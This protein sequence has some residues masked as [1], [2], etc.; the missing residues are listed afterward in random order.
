MPDV[1]LDH[2]AAAADHD[3][4]DA[5]HL[6][7]LVRVVVHPHVVRVRVVDADRFPAVRVEDDQVGVAAHSDGPLLREQP[8]QLGGRGRRQLDELVHR[9][10]AARH[11]AVVD[12]AHPVLD[13]R[14]AV[15]D[16][17]EVVYPQNLLV[18]ETERA[19]VGRDALQIAEPEPPPQ[20]VL[21]PLLPQRRRHDVLGALEVLL[22]VA[23]Q[24][25]E[26][27]LGAGLGEHLSAAVP[28]QGH[29]FERVRAAQVDDVDRHARHLGDRDRAMHSLRLHAGG[30]GQ[31]VVLRRRLALGHCQLDDLVDDDPVLGVHA[32]QGAVLA[33][34][35]H[36]AE[37]RAV[38]DV[39]QARVGHEHLV[40]GHALV[41][42]P[43]HLPQPVVLHVGDDHVEA[44]VDARLAGRLLVPGLEPLKRRLA[45]G[46]DREVDDR[47]RTA[48]GGRPGAGLEV[49]G[50]RRA[51][52]GHVHVGVGVDA[53]RH[54]QP[55][56]RVD[57]PVRLDLQVAADQRDR[58][59]LYEDV[60]AVVVHRRHDATVTNQQGHRLLLSCRLSASHYYSRSRNCC[61]VSPAV[62]MFPR[63]V[64]TATSFRCTGI[65]TGR[66]QSSRSMIA[67]PPV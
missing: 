34:L 7:A 65:T 26:Q 35:A 8:E 10:P 24:V 11:A 54:D 27:V 3:L 52:E 44:V 60:G 29:L 45:L 12:Q 9:Q 25:Q 42:Q 33:G 55:P 22:V 47:R 40:G 23:A 67:C 1:V 18:L 57:G 28:R 41:G 62:L 30:T 32:D 37:Q 5:L 48:E 64:P 19:V 16:L 58:L 51:A 4:G 39:E 66:S 20:V 14:G 2:H 46:L 38:V 17:A 15:R 31:G 59:V 56:R 43:P 21:V 61:T 63:S 50:A 6:D 13:P 53:A 36:G 49:V